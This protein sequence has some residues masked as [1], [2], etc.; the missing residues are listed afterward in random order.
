MR[1]VERALRVFGAAFGVHPRG[2]NWCRVRASELEKVNEVVSVVVVW[3]PF[4]FTVQRC[5]ER[6]PVFAIKRAD[7][8]LEQPPGVEAAE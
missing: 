2:A 3:G 1:S 7:G 4:R 6:E 8:S 5:P